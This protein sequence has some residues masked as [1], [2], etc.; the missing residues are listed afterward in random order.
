MLDALNILQPISQSKVDV[1]ALQAADIIAHQSARSI[2]TETQRAKE[3]KRIYTDRLFEKPGIQVHATRKLVREW[4]IE[5]QFIE[6]HRRQG[7]YLRS[8]TAAWMRTLPQFYILVDMFEEPENHHIT[9]ML[10]ELR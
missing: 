2:L 7:L 1:H 8:E 5:G 6:S 10:R 9:S 4:Y 3:T